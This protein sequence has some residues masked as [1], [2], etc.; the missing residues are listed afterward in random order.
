MLSTVDFFKRWQSDHGR[1]NQEI[2]ILSAGTKPGGI[3]AAIAWRERPGKRKRSTVFFERTSEG[4]CQSDE[5]WNCSKGNL[6]D[7]S[8]RRDEA[9]TGFSERIDTIFENQREPACLCQTRSQQFSAS[10]GRRVFSFRSS[11]KCDTMQTLE[12]Q[13][14]WQLADHHN[15]HLSRWALSS[16][17][18]QLTD[19]R[20]WLLRN[21]QFVLI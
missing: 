15:E 10:S 17:P 7:T 8:E 6:E 14:S 9:H 21:T 5:H 1:H 19:K 4:H 16:P 3:T 20:Q 11:F 18:W 13:S 2:E 12:R